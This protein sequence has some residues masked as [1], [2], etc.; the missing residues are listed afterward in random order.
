MLNP[1]CR[2]INELILQSWWE[3]MDFTALLNAVV[4]A[5]TNLALPRDLKVP[6]ADK[7]I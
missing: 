1:E 4:S 2:E 5:L 7:T 3:T 6:Y